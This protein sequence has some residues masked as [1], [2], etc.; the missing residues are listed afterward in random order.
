MYLVIPED[1]NVPGYSWS[2]E[3][4]WLFL[5]FERTWL[6]LKRFVHTKVDIYVFYYLKGRRMGGYGV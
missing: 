5:K 3:R 4:T 2:F 1:L 6:F